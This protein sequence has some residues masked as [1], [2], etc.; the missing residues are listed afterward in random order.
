MKEHPMKLA[1][2]AILLTTTA[3]NA[4]NYDCLIDPSLVVQVGSAEVGII[5]K[6][7]VERGD[8]VS[9]GQPIAQLESGAELAALEYA[10]ARAEDTSPIEIAQ[11][12]VDLMKSEADRAQ[13]LGQKNLLATA[14]VDAANSEYAMSVLALRQAEFEKRL[15][16]LDQTRVEAQIARREIKSPIDGIVITRMIGPGEYVFAQAPVVQLAK[17]NPL[18]I[19]VFLPTDQY[20]NLHIGQTATVMPAQPIGGSYTAK[21]IV[22]DRVFDAASDTF[23]VRLSLDN[24]QGKLV[25][26]VDCQLRFD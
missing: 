14:M 24:P 12:R 11:A 13:E 25:A 10:K 9:A 2:I 16:A 18:H 17:I 8:L 19:E 6:V 22:I 23:G 5:E 15:S 26:G 1:I 3:A 4:A 20:S 7:M 21:I